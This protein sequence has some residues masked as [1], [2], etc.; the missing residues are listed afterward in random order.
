MLITAR[1]QSY[2]VYIGRGVFV[3]LYSGS[4]L[5]SFLSNINVEAQKN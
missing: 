4:A 3:T 5:I 2:T 1:K